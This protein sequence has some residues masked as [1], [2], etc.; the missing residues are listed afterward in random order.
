MGGPAG[1]RIMT[2]TFPAPGAGPLERFRAFYAAVADLRRRVQEGAWPPRDS[3]AALQSAQFPLLALLERFAETAGEGPAGSPAERQARY[4]MAAFADDLFTRLDGSLSEA[5]SA[6]SLESQLF[7]TDQAAGVVFERID[8]LLEV[9]DPGRRELARLYLMALALGFRG[10]YRDDSA[11]ALGGYRE[12]L[13][14]FAVAR[15]QQDR[16][17]GDGSPELSPG[18]YRHTRGQVPGSLLPNVRRWAL[19]AVV[20]VALVGV[21]SI[22]LWRDAT[23]SIGSAVERVLNR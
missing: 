19:A 7:Q 18:A 10:R 13:L 21:L 8:A 20:A 14:A 17:S 3:G 9:G 23:R 6:S 16:E 15:S 1:T 2:S 12:R 4:L 11:G 5:W 22:P